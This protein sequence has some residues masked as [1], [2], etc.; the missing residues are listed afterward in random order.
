MQEIP[1]LSIK[2]RK[3]LCELEK[4]ARRSNRAIAKK[5]GLHVDVVR[6]R[7][8]KLI[9]SGIIHS[10]LTFVNFAK[11]G[12]T[13]YGVF[14]S[15]QHLTKEKEQEITD[16]LSKNEHVSYFAKVG[17]KFDFIMG[18]LSRN[19]VEF[20]HALSGI[21]E[22]IGAYVLTKDIAVRVVL[23]HYPKLYLHNKKSQ[24]K[25][26]KY[27]YF[28]GE[29]GGETLDELDKK[30]LQKMATNARI[31]T[32]ALG[33]LLDK[34]ASTIALRIKKLQERKIIVGFYCFT[35]PQH[36]GYEAYDVTLN[37]KNMSRQNEKRLLFFFEKHP[38]IIYAIK[39]VGKWDYEIMVEV[40]NQEQFQEILAELKE[41]F[42]DVIQSLEFVTM[43]K[44]IKYNLFPFK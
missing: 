19:I 41:K 34:P 21:M 35:S 26:E 29:Y 23:K 1:E 36:Y 3:I 4:N 24:E 31:T 13:D 33:E 44:D 28:G 10:F 37:V 17:G 20:N 25:P 38:N 30:I 11:L 2:D 12:Y 16:Y 43:F 18:I 5:V 27:P 7:I 22:H 42:S 14:F 15:T 8:N 40:Q 9:E 6:Y 39:C 32:V